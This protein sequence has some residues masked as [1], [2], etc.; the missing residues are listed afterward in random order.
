MNNIS[1]RI[2]QLLTNRKLTN[3]KIC[4]ETG[5]QQATFGRSLRTQNTWKTE[6]LV[7]IAEFFNVSIDWL[8]TGK[9]FDEEQAI[10]KLRDDNIQQ[11]N[12]IK[13]L[14]NEN[15]RLRQAMLVLLEETEVGDTAII[16][17]LPKIVRKYSEKGNHKS[18]VSDESKERNRITQKR[19]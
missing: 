16:N 14:E 6:H 12:I 18:T 4:K 5:I 1:D 8:I 15:R 10:A 19:K 13:E 11:I 17:D 7:K 9:N 2:R 3:Y